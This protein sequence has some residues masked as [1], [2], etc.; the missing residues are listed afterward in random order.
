MAAENIADLAHLRTVHCWDVER[1]VVPPGAHPDGTFRVAVDVRWRL[2]ARSRDPRVQRLGRLVH[3]PF[4]LDVRAH[5]AGIVVAHATL[6]EAQGSLALR[7]I[8]LVCPLGD[9]SARLRVLVSVRRQFEGAAAQALRRVTGRG[10]EELLA[11]LF[12]AIGVSDFNSDAMVWERRTHLDNPVP[13]QGE[14]AFLEF[15]QWSLRFWPDDHAP[16][17][18]APADLYGPSQVHS[19]PQ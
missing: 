18:P 14:G 1:V 10:L 19:P 5:D 15:R 8:V 6:T 13:L 12:L 4:H 9:G 2:G 16:D 7:N 17:V 11:P 3:S